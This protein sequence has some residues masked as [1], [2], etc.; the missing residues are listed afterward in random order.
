M[1][2]IDA[3]RAILQNRGSIEIYVR[4]ADDANYAQMLIGENANFH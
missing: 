1:Q 3:G 4:E 2:T